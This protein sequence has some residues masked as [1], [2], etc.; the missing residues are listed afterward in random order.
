MRQEPIGVALVS[1]AHR[2]TELG[3]TFEQIIA[4]PHLFGGR[5]VVV[6]GG[7]EFVTKMANLLMQTGCRSGVLGRLNHE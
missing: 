3:K 4:N 1:R 2:N 5:R 7:L 6:G